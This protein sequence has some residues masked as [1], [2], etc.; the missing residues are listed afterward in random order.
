V[1]FAGHKSRMETK[2]MRI[3]NCG[4]RNW[5]DRQAIERELKKTMHLAKHGVII[6]DGGASG[7]DSIGHEIAKSMNLF[8]MRFK[9]DWKRYGK[10]AGPIRN[11]EMITVGKPDIIL[12]F[13]ACIEKSRGTADMIDKAKKYKIPFLL[14]KE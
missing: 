5:T 14:F 6:I 11:Q 12:A 4:D 9:A 8:T 3:L 1:R 2:N 13:H 10:A 7:A